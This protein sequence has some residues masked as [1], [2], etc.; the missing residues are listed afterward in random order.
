MVNELTQF[1]IVEGRSCWPCNRRF[2]CSWKNLGKVSRTPTLR[3]AMVYPFLSLRAV[4]LI[5][6]VLLIALHGLAIA[7]SHSVRPWLKNLPRSMSAGTVLLALDAL[8][9][10]LLIYFMDL[11]EFS[12]LRK[13]LLILIPIAAVLTYKFVDEFLAVRALGI[14][15]LLAAEP[16]LEAA[17]LRPETSRLLLV[18]LA[19]AWA[20]LGMFWVGMPYL[21]RDQIEWVGKTETRWKIACGAG[22]FYGVVMCATALI[23]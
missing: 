23:G 12:H 3:R 9:A 14:L 13:P 11:G 17:F 7:Q 16:L 1:V 8:W 20:V 15:L 2:R 5:V 4:A 6:G 18:S 21:L 19:Y 22:L 10:F